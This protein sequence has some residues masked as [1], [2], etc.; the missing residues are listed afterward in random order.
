M[1]L[2]HPLIPYHLDPDLGA[3]DVRGVKRVPFIS[4]ELPQLCQRGEKSSGQE[5]DVK[6]DLG[7]LPGPGDASSCT[8][9]KLLCISEF[10][11]EILW[12]RLP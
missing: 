1:L 7:L 9:S 11:H 4:G 10:S 6:L 12:T 5:Q 8:M 3:V 2:V